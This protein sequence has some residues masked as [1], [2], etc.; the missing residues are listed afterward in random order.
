MKANCSINVLFFS[1]TCLRTYHIYSNSITSLYT[2]SQ[3]KTH[4]LWN[5]TARNYD[6]QFWW[7]LAEIF[8][9]LQNGVC[10]F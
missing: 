7:H 10:P 8:K 3:K 6:D 9:I 4:Q 2:V 5:G 1:K